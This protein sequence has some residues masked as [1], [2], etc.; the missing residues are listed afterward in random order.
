MID[1]VIGTA[2]HVDHGKT[3]LIKALT[4]MDTDTLAQEKERG[5]SINL[6][7]AHL[8][9]ADGRQIGIVDVPGHE[10]FIKNMVAGLPGL[11]LVLL[12]VD[13]GEGV[14]PQTREHVNILELL[15]I[16]KFIIVLTKV[17]TVDAEVAELAIED[18]REQFTSVALSEAPVILT[19]A[20]SGRGIDELKQLIRDECEKLTAKPNDG[21]ARVNIDRVFSSR[22]FGTV[23]TG[24]LIDGNLV[25]G[26]EVFLYLTQDQH[27]DYVKS[28]IRNIQSYGHASDA[29]TSGQRVALNL[30]DLK[31][32]ELTRGDVLSGAPSLSKSYMLDVNVQ[33][34]SDHSHTLKL[35][36][37]VRVLIGTREVMARLVPLGCT[38]IAVGGSGFAQ[39]R[40][41]EPLSVKKQ[42]R[43]IL[44]TYSPIE[45]IAGG[46]VLDSSPSKH[47][48]FD[49]AL[50]DSLT[51]KQIGDQKALLVDYV[52]GQTELFVTVE[53]LR[54]YLNVSLV[55]VERLIGDLTSEQQIIK[56]DN[57][58]TSIAKFNR[59]TQAA[60]GEM[61]RFHSEYP[62]RSGMPKEEFRQKLQKLFGR[63]TELMLDLALQK[64]LIVLDG[65]VYHLPNF[66]VKLT[67]E[68]K[69]L[70]DF[71]HK[72]LIESSFTAISVKELAG[73]RQQEDLC[74]SLEGEVLIFLDAEYMIAV[75]T[76]RRA[77]ELTKTFFSKNPKMTLA[78]F[79][80]FTESS[81]KNSMLILEYMD[82]Q[83]LTQRVENYRIKGKRLLHE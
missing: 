22:G 8:D 66:S 78:D 1:L 63:K 79:R 41:E 59:F 11:S 20:L 16:E 50:L 25:K 6:G 23:V 34:L 30:A 72:R 70:R 36:D 13:A 32:E 29:A 18:V 7:F 24:T 64:N 62:L 82:R 57:L 48:R 43:F 71:I 40:L 28:R 52:D 15:G 21:I 3:T 27:H 42:D 81:R 49:Q 4:N 31:R 60:L 47:R 58:C 68:Q 26:Q 51:V 10:R 74:R 83:N 35:W 77:V 19:D 67:P 75:E 69:R 53:S 56:I 9:Y 45:T 37:R 39:L 2:G 12:V 46:E 65:N 54:D 5:I 38:E 76:Y 17:D 73:N 80:D 44:R 33:S 14:M 61:T 55:E